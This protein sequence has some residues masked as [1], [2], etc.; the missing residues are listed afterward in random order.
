MMKERELKNA[1]TRA[2]NV[3]KEIQRIKRQ[4]DTNY[5]LAAITELENEIKSKE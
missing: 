2:F 1:Q 3:K 4:L 5:D